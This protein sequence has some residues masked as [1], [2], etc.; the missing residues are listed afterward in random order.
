[1]VASSNPVV[2]IA[3]AS[4][5]KKILLETFYAYS[6]NKWTT[7]TFDY[8]FI[9]T[10]LTTPIVDR[11]RSSPHACMPSFELGPL[12]LADREANHGALRRG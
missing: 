11:Y 1:M 4:P 3:G 12:T 10:P 2:L 5:M 9:A 8:Q 6:V 7:A